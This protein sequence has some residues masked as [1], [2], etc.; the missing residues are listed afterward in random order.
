MADIPIPNEARQALVA[1]YIRDMEDAGLQPN[2]ALATGMAN[3]SLQCM[4]N[5]LLD[6]DEPLTLGCEIP[7][8]LI[9]FVLH[10]SSTLADRAADALENPE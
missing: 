7:E 1:V 5:I 4:A 8:D 2:T 9:D 6:V 10:W 3:L